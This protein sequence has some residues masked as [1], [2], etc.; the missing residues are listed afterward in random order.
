[1]LTL[2]LATV[3]AQA[4]AKTVKHTIKNGETLY[5]IAKK[6]HTTIEEVRKANGLKKGDTLKLGSVLKVP[7]NTYFPDKKKKV[8]KVTK[9]KSKKLAKKTNK[10]SNIK[11]SSKSAKYA[12]KNGDTLFTIARKHHTT[13]EE[14]KKANDLKKGETLKLGRVLKVPKNTYFPNKKKNIK[15]AIKNKKIATR[16]KNSKKLVKKSEKKKHRIVR[17]KKSRQDKKLA[18]ALMNIKSKRIVRAKT[19]KSTKFSLND[20]FFHGESKNKSTK[21]TRLA[22]KKLGKRYVWGAVGQK[23]TFD[24]SGLTSYV[25]KKNGINIPRRAIAQSKYGKYIK[26]NQLKPGDLIFFDTSKRHKGYV[27]H[28]G[29]YLGNDKFIHASSAKKKVVITRLSKSFYSKRYKGARRVTS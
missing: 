21:M 4:A 25:C 17:V 27:N 22:K 7:K 3:T 29:I 9:K 8:A 2:S 13:I 16:K 28:V 15:V 20:I 26:R 10:K 6:N 14:V 18:K 24:C 5:T 11:K 12:I 19:K 1:L 23:N